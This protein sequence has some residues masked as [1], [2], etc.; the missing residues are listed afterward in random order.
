[1][2]EKVVKHKQLVGS[3]VFVDEVPKLQGGKVQR[4]LVKQ[5]AKGDA[6][7]MEYAKFKAEL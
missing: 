7:R 6:E 3:I 4:A 1:M 2:K 5:W